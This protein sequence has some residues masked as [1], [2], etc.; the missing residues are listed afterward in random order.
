MS[1]DATFLIETLLSH[2]SVS[3]SNQNKREIPVQNS[4]R[5]VSSFTVEIWV[6]NDWIQSQI[7]NKMATEPSR[8]LVFLF[9]FSNKL[10]DTEKLK[11][12]KIV[13]SLGGEARVQED[14]YVSDATHVIVP[15]TKQE[16]CPKIIGALAGCK[17]V[18]TTDYLIQCAQA[19]QLLPITDRFIP[20]YLRGLT[21]NF[22]E[23][24]KPFKGLK[25]LVVVKSHR[26]QTE[27]KII[28]RDGGATVHNW[29]LSDIGCKPIDDLAKIDIVY[30]DDVLSAYPA[31][32]KFYDDRKDSGKP[33]K[34][35]SYFGLF[36]V[37]QS[38]PKNVQE[39]EAIASQFDV[40]NLTLMAKLH[41][42]IKLSLARQDFNA[43]K[44]QAKDIC[45]T[46]A[47]S[48]EEDDDIQIVDEVKKGEMTKDVQYLPN[49]GK[50]RAPQIW[51]EVVD[52]V[53]SDGDSSDGYQVIDSD[54]EEKPKESKPVVSTTPTTPSTPTI[55]ST[56]N[57]TP[58]EISTTQKIELPESSGEN[59]KKR[60]AIKHF[61]ISTS[62]DKSN[63]EPKKK[64]FRSFGSSAGADGF[65]MTTLR[66]DPILKKEEKK[67]NQSL[68]SKLDLDI[69]KGKVEQ[70]K[71][72]KNNGDTK[73]MEIKED[74]NKM[75]IK[76]DTKKI[77]SSEQKE[78]T[79][80]IEISNQ[81]E[82]TKKIETSERKDNIV[83]TE[84]SHNRYCS[85]FLKLTFILYARWRS[86]IRFQKNLSYL[87][88][89]V[90]CLFTFSSCLFT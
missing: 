80:K 47:S 34:V 76:E 29:T 55:Q 73:K 86:K 90:H 18:L 9:A 50:K 44:R 57:K 7:G 81:K 14:M 21:A 84:E 15:N 10:S 87:L 61:G 53:D 28:L 30:T 25:A 8:K 38:G 49:T 11:Y 19:N 77:E 27:L 52:L 40:S 68:N 51:P 83:D 26:R 54:N 42:N 58:V 20:S 70:I 33:L 71:E 89:L 66:K 39:R 62:D 35:S 12:Q 13:T 31:L 48:D 63:P 46:I 6:L 75:E 67:E 69:E 43:P 16:W 32:Q 41:P 65:D 60:K 56:P 79:K 37:V 1:I 24:G 5:F 74:T 45:I 64:K 36:K 85:T 3:I 78:D 4:S 88:L 17:D 2:S 23:N 22:K 72:V 59:E 82:D